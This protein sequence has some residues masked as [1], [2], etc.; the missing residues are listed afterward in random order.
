MNISEK[1][2]NESG[3]IDRPQLMD[4]LE[5]YIDVGDDLSMLEGMK[6]ELDARIEGD[7]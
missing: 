3:D 1:F 5:Q 4:D 6:N 2:Q 7:E